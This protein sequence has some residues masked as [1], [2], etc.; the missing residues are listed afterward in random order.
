VNRSVLLRIHKINRAGQRTRSSE[1]CMDMCNSAVT[2]G[3]VVKALFAEVT[4]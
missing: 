2:R 3:L 4:V 1:L